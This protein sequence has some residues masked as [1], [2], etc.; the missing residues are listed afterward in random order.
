MRNFDMVSPSFEESLELYFQQCSV[1]VSTR[2]LAVMGATLANGGLNPFSGQR[3]IDASYVKYLLS[4]MLSCGMYDYAG[5]WAYR[6]GIPS[7]SGVSVVS[8]ASCRASSGSESIHQHS[9]LKATAF[10]VFVSSK[11]YRDKFGMHI[12]EG[13]SNKLSIRDLFTPVRGAVS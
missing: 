11:S 9:M 8:S 6:V 3:A 5:E 13:G 4:I 10:E 7:K 2:D 12:F 1:L